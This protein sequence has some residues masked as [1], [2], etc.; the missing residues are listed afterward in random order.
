MY[1]TCYP[2]TRLRFA[3]FLIFTVMKV[4]LSLLLGLEESSLPKDK[5]DS[6]HHCVTPALVVLLLQQPK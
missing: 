1:F 5:L 4:P 3:H 6:I 2:Q